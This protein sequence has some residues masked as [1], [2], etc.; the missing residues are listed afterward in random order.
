MEIYAATLHGNITSDV[1]KK[2]E[3]GHPFTGEIAIQRELKPKL[4]Q[5]GRP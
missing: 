4:T 3:E 1:N 5:T 2:R